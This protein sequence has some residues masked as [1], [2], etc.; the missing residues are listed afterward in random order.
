MR[1]IT[2]SVEYNKIEFDRMPAKLWGNEIGLHRMDGPA[3]IYDSFEGM[4]KDYYL[5]GIWIDDEEEARDRG[6]Q[7]GR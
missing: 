6:I 5:N 3:F 2:L 4:N 7:T 1:V